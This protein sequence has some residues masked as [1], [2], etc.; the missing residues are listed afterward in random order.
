MMSVNENSCQNSRKFRV[1]VSEKILLGRVVAGAAGGV[2]QLSSLQRA[3]P[4]KLP[5]DGPAGAPLDE[6]QKSSLFRLTRAKA[7]SCR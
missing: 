5:F 4:M 2:N 6:H 1:T 7:D 3:R